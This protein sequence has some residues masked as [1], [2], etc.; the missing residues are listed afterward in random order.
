MYASSDK[1]DSLANINANEEK[2]NLLFCDVWNQARLW[3]LQEVRLSLQ[4]GIKK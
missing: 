3:G 4:V 2:L 1:E